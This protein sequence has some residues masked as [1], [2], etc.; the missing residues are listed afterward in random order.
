MRTYSR[1]SDCNY[2]DGVFRSRKSGETW[3]A[4]ECR[5]RRSS[6]YCGHFDVPH[7]SVGTATS[8]VEICAMTAIA[9][10]TCSCAR[11]RSLRMR[12]ACSGILNSRPGHS[13]EV[14]SSGFRRAAS[15]FGVSRLRPRAGSNG[16][17]NALARYLRI[18][19]GGS[20]ALPNRATSIG[21]ARNRR[22]RGRFSTMRYVAA[23]RF[24][25]R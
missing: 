9:W 23:N 22:R 11:W 18:R 14:A 12:G 7:L 19:P 4:T 24:P 6:L 8:F 16:G 21:S 15:F 13:D 10:C 2:V 5:I 1:V 25:R 20:L 3:A 17:T